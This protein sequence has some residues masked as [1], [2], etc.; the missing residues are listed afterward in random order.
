[1]RYLAW[2][3]KALMFILVL[4]F[5]LKNADPVEVRYYL[6]YSWQAPL[7]FVLLVFFCLGVVAGIFAG[8]SRVYRQRREILA[9]KKALRNQSQ[10]VTPATPWVDGA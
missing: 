10:S 5:A 6:G 4:G 1:M 8:L 2:V 9:L 3:V 7:V